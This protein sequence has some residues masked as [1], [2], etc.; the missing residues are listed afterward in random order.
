MSCRIVSRGVGTVLLSFLM[1]QAKSG[2]K[3][4]EADFVRTDRNRQ[5]LLTYQ[6]ANFHV[7]RREGAIIVY[8]NDLSFIQD[9]PSYIQVIEENSFEPINPAGRAIGFEK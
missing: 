1:K 3:R 5:M 9:Y 6:L 7:Q 4:L 2:G 8:E